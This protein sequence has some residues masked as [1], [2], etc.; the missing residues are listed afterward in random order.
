MCFDDDRD[1]VRLLAHLARRID[2]RRPG[3]RLGVGVLRRWAT[4]GVDG[5]RLK[6]W[7]VGGRW[8]STWGN[9]EAFLGAHEVPPD[10][11]AAFWQAAALVAC[12]APPA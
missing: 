12:G 3:K 8:F 10:A 4:R 5:V 9:V 1:V 6:A 11:R 7:K 2:G